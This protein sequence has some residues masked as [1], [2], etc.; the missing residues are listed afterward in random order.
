MPSMRDQGPHAPAAVIVQALDLGPD[1]GML[2]VGCD[3]EHVNLAPGNRLISGHAGKPIGSLPQNL[4]C[5]PRLWRRC[6]AASCALSC[7]AS[8]FA[9]AWRR[10]SAAS[11]LA[12]RRRLAAVAAARACLRSSAASARA[13]PPP[14]RPPPPAP[15]PPPPPPPRP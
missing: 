2:N 14:P 10:S 7:A 11:R 9:A 4:G 13:L 15:L 5:L 1:S 3:F 12:A 6:H 8:A